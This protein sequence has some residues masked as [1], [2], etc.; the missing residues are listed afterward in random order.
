MEN[1]D[2]LTEIMSDLEF[3][4]LDSQKRLTL[5][6]KS[7]NYNKGTILLNE[8]YLLI[9]ALQA[10]I[11]NLDTSKMDSSEIKNTKK[12]IDLLS[13]PNLNFKELMYISKQLKSIS[14]GLKTTATITDNI[15]NQV[16]YEEEEI[17]L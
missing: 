3:I 14:S 12:L 10:E 8:A 15:E 11:D 5:Q 17:A 6:K 4:R 9:D 16:I 2:K 13:M 1:S 7:E